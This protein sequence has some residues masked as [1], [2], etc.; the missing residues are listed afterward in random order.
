MLEVLE[1]ASKIYIL[2][3]IVFHS[4]RVMSMMK[5]M[6]EVTVSEVRLAQFIT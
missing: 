6:S 3:F 5:V 1:Q 4:I 2:S